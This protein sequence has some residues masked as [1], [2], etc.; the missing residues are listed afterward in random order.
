MVVKVEAAAVRQ[1]PLSQEVRLRFGSRKLS[2]Q[3]QLMLAF[4]RSKWG[5][6]ESRPALNTAS[7]DDGGTSR[8]A[9][10]RENRRLAKEVEE[11]KRRSTTSSPRRS[12]G[13]RATEVAIYTDEDVGED[14]GASSEDLDRADVADD[15]AEADLLLRRLQK[16]QY[17]EKESLRRPAA[18]TGSPARPG[19]RD[20]GDEQGSDLG[21]ETADADTESRRR[22]HGRRAEG[23]RPA[24]RARG[25]GAARPRGGDDAQSQAL[26]LQME[27]Q[28][29]IL[30]L[31]KEMKSGAGP[32]VVE[33]PESNELDSL[34]VMKSLGRMRALKEGLHNNPRNICREYRET[35]IAQ[36]GA[37]GKGYRWVDRNRHIR[38]KKFNSVRRFDWILCHVLEQ[39]DAGQTDVARAHLVQAMKCLHEFA[40]HGSWSAAWPHTHLVDPLKNQLNGAT[41]PEMEAVLGYLKL[42]DDI[43][44]RLLKGTRDLVSDDDAVDQTPK[45]PKQKDKKKGKGAGKGEDM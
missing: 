35:W 4:Y 29:E 13:K 37:E 24:V 15:A 26:T 20:D 19:R 34:R 22:G 3:Q 11:L 32:I 17:K 30:K 16:C 14:D 10:E 38:W 27:V 36:L 25:A 31:L 43:K 33:A 23:R 45:D 41:E 5:S 2:G 6:S 44:Q 9:L 39:L 8:R 28:L 18:S 40:N 1:E 42:E 7:T 21:G 12:R